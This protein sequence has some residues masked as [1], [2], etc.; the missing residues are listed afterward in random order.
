[1][2]GNADGAGG[3]VVRQRLAALVDAMAGGEATA[4]S[5]AGALAHFRKVTRSYWQGNRIWKC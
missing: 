3:A 4:G 2:L 5:L 1:M